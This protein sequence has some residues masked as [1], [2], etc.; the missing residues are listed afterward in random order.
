[1]PKLFAVIFA[2]FLLALPARAAPNAVEAILIKQFLVCEGNLAAGCESFGKTAF[3]DALIVFTGAVENGSAA[4]Q[5]NIAMLYETGAGVA[6]DNVKAAELYHI[7]AEAGV[8]I[9]QYN[10]AML[11]VTK[12][13]IGEVTDQ[14]ERD[15][16]MATAY[17]WLTFASEKGLKLAIESRQELIE[18]MSEGSLKTA[19]NRLRKRREK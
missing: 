17:M 4:A 18:F 8:S 6:Q 3:S 11:T 16:D 12:H 10:L 5:N 9:A 13:V 19:K 14:Q 1:M 7:A 2:L 15:T